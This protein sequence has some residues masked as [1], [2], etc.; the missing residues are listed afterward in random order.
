MRRRS[1]D[2]LGAASSRHDWH[3]ACP[4]VAKSKENERIRGRKYDLK[5]VIASD[6]KSSDA[7]STGCDLYPLLEVSGVSRAVANLDTAQAPVELLKCVEEVDEDPVFTIKCDEERE[8]IRRRNHITEDEQK[9]LIKAS[10]LLDTPSLAREIVRNHLQY[11]D[12]EHSAFLTFQYATL[13][14]TIISQNNMCDDRLFLKAIEEVER[15]RKRLLLKAKKE[16]VPNGCGTMHNQVNEFFADV[17]ND[18][19]NNNQISSRRLPV[20]PLI[21]DE[22]EKVKVKLPRIGNSPLMKRSNNNRINSDGKTTMKLRFPRSNDDPA[23]AK[24]LLS[25]KLDELKAL[26]HDKGGDSRSSEGEPAE[27]RSNSSKSSLFESLENEKFKKLLD[28]ESN[29]SVVQGSSQ[30]STPRSLNYMKLKLRAAL[31]A[32]DQ[33]S[34]F[35]YD[36][37][38]TPKDKV[39]C[40]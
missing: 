33:A 18:N 19:T 12:E 20:S 6:A 11:K 4:A 17:L 7:K 35:I 9:T 22:L 23:I 16:V 10:M 5:A 21:V 32:G 8:R 40:L 14:N 29:E 34:S 28:L 2:S 1:L 37:L 3:V 38:F 15:C 36:K 30:G 24:E 26:F 27:L 13:R 39:Q 25:S 31:H